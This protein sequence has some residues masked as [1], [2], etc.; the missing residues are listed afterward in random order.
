MLDA[1]YFLHIVYKIYKKLLTENKMYVKNFSSHA[2]IWKLNKNLF[3]KN[4]LTNFLISLPLIY[5]FTK[6]F[7]KQKYLFK[8]FIFK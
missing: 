3:N 7:A 2:F 1:I 8:T 6:F 5:L 4:K